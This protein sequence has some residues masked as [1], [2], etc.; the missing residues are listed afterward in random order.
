MNKLATLL[1]PLIVITFLAG[2]STMDINQD[3]DPTANFASYKTYSWVPGPQPK[4]G[5]ARLDND[6]L[7][8]RIR[9]AV[10]RQL[11]LKGYQKVDPD[12][13]LDLNPDFLVSYH[14]SIQ[15]KLDVT[16][17]PGNAYMSPLIQADGTFGLGW[18]GWDEETFVTTYDEGTILLDFADAKTKKLVWRG[19]VSDVV[20]PDKSPEKREASIVNAMQK[21]L[22]QFP[23]VVKQK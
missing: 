18:D 1:L 21:V 5:D 14:T 3:Y 20:D 16:T 2:C 15:G 22:M 12:Q 11:L 17:V 6:L 8:T 9:T 4:T 23:P 10:D 7:D 13:K 19:S